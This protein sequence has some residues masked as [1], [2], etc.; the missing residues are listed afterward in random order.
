VASLSSRRV[1]L[2]LLTA[3][4]ALAAMLVGLPGLSTPASAA[5]RIMGRSAVTAQELA[6]WFASTGQQPNLPVS[7]RT[8]AT[9]FIR[10]GAAE[11]VRGDL[12]FAQSI[13]ETGYFSFP[14][15]GQVRPSHNNYA[16]LGAVDGGNTPNRFPTPQIGVRA[17]IQHLRAYAD[18]R[19]TETNLANP[20]VSPRFHLVSPKGR[21]RTWEVMGGKAADGRV[22][23]ASDPDY[24]AKVLGIFGRITRYVDALRSSTPLAGDW[25][26]NGVTTPGWF[27]DGRFYLKN[28]NRPGAPDVVFSFGRRGDLPVVGDWNGNG[29]DTVGVI[30][31]GD[32]YLR[33][34]L[35]GGPAD[36]AFRYGRVSN[37][38][39]P[40]TGD[41]NGD[42]HTTVGVVRDG[43]W[44]LRDRL[45]G[46]NADVAFVYGR[47]LRGDVPVTGDWNGDGHTTIGV[48]RGATWHLRNHNS[49]GTGEWAFTYGRASDVAVP[50]DWNGDRRSTPGVVRGTAWHLQSQLSGG[51]ASHSFN[52][53]GW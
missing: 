35:A 8:L 6:D 26:G 3:A 33:D 50:G 36:H 39:Y 17:Q 2:R 51:S 12:A 37:G 14:A 43:H 21:A 25:N 38:D 48:V 24:G 22:N 28:T 1:G 34:A 52:Y 27:K 49:G 4:A 16:G 15:A 53:T 30:R 19:V 29:R 11:G 9:H 44:Y 47:V 42:G 45:D 7:V 10:E 41:W 23:W 18:P 5:T 46:G 32:W 40:V 13:L 20:L 31:D